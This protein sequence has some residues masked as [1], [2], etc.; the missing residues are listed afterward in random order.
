MGHADIHLAL[1]STLVNISIN[2]VSSR[3]QVLSTLLALCAWPTAHWV[4][5]WKVLQ[6]LIRYVSQACTVYTYTVHICNLLAVFSTHLDLIRNQLGPQHIQNRS[7][8]W[9]WYELHELLQNVHVQNRLAQ[10]LRDIYY[11]YCQYNLCCL[12]NI[13]GTSNLQKFY[14]WAI[15]ILYKMNIH[16]YTENHIMCHVRDN[17]YEPLD[18]KQKA[19]L[20]V[21]ARSSSV[22]RPALVMTVSLP[23][24]NRFCLSKG[25]LEQLF[26]MKFWQGLV[27]LFEES[28][29]TA[30][31]GGAQ[32][33][34]ADFLVNRLWLLWV[35]WRPA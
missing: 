2:D 9:T 1:Q 5:L 15:L 21:M 33:L 10:C 20:T 12:Y 16:T 11:L 7:P 23:L 17:V 4:N 34:M 18:W 30:C 8:K 31:R 14:V 3:G 13:S 6:R 26:D 32:Q 19:W 22:C 25:A 24:G 35:A 29:V 27:V 28:L